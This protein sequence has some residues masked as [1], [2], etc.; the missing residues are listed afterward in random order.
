VGLKVARANELIRIA[1]G[2]TTIEESRAGKS[3]RKV[4]ARDRMLRSIQSSSITT[5]AAI[6]GRAPEEPAVEEA[7]IAIANEARA[8]PDE[9]DVIALTNSAIDAAKQVLLSVALVSDLEM[10]AIA[11]AER[12]WLQAAQS[13][14]AKRRASVDDAGSLKPGTTLPPAGDDC[15]DN[16]EQ[17]RRTK[18]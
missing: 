9:I 11:R 16:P 7:V 4:Q 14:R 18:H 17:F 5:P 13:V 3:E 8:G 12:A 6:Q 10:E 15:P 1:D 2:R